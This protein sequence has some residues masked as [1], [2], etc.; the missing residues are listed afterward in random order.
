MGMDT[1]YPQRVLVTGGLGFIFGHVVE[2]ISREWPRARIVVLDKCTYAVMPET[3]ARI[4]AL[5]NVEVITGCVTNA[6]LLRLLWAQHDFTHVVHAAAET[7]VD[8]SFGNSLVFTHSNVLGTHTMLEAARFHVHES[9]GMPSLRMFVHVSTDEVIGTSDAAHAAR[10]RDDGSGALLL[11]TNPYAASKA[12]AEL[13]AVTYRDTYG[14]PVVI[15][16]GNNVYGPR[17]HPEKLVARCIDRAARG[18]PL[19]IHGSGAQVR[20]FLHVRDVATAFVEIIRHDLEAVAE[21]MFLI[22]AD[23]EVSIRDVVRLIAEVT[24]AEVEYVPDPRPFNDLRYIAGMTPRLRA[25]LAESREAPPLE[26][27]PFA[28]RF[29]DNIAEL[30]DARTTLGGVE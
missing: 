2:R 26:D 5:D 1:P 17:Q 8:R 4:R 7:H 11:P 27:R 30:F 21:K 28:A 22:G 6:D 16:R 15:T 25:W 3:E 12:A 9:R 13:F 19:Q 24:A 29:A 10:H 18:L 14:L 23:D 20:N